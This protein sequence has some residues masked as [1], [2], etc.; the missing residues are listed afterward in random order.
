LVTITGTNLGSPTAFTIGG[1]AAIVISNTGT[2]MVGM[3]MPGAVTGT[4]SLTTAGGSVTSAGTF[5]VSATPAPNAQQGAKLVGTG[6]TGT[7]QQGYA[8]SVSADGNTA[9][10]GG[11]EDDSSQGAAWIYTRSAGVWS[12]QGAKLVGTGNTG[13]ARQGW[14]VSL[15]A[16]GNTAIVGGWFD[17]SQE[18]AAWIYTRSGTTW[19][20]QGAK[21]VGTGNTGAARQGWSV[22]LSADGNTA[23]LGGMNDNSQQG[24]AWIFTRN[25]TTWNQQGAKLVGTGNTGAAFQGRAV[26]LSADGN[27]AIVGG[28]ADN[29]NQ[30]ATWIFTR[31][32]T[33]WSQQGAKLV[34]T[35]NIGEAQQ[36]YS[37]SLSANG[38]TAILGGFADNSY[39]GATWIFTRSGTTW[40]QQGN[41]LVGTGGSNDARQGR[42]VSL[43]ADGNT[44]IVGGLND[45][46]NQGAAWIFTRS[47]TTW[48]QQGTKRIG[49]G[50]IGE[51]QQGQA[52]SLSAD[53][54]TAIVGGIV[55]DSGQGAAWVYHYIPP[56][57]I[58]SFTPASGPV[59][60]LVTITGTNLGSPTAFTIGGIAAI[61]ISNDG[62]SLVGMVMPGA[63]TGTLSVTTVGGSVTAG[64]TFTISTLSG[65]YAQ[66]GNKLLGTGNTGN[67]NQGQVVSVSADGNTAIVGGPADDSNQGAV[68]IYTRSGNIWSQQGT[69]LVGTGNTG[70][71][72]QGIAVSISADG[73]TTI[74]GGFF[75]N[76]GQGAA[77][78]F[79]RSGTTWSQQGNKLVGTGNIGAAQ[80]GIAVSISADGNTAVVGGRNDNTNQGAAWVY[81]RNGA[82][83][84]QQGNKLVGTGGIPGLMQQGTSVSVSADGNTAIVGAPRDNSDQGAAWIYTRSGTTWSQQGTK[85]VGTGNTGTAY[86]GYAVSL[87]AD[88][89]TAMMG[90]FTDNANRGAAWV[91]SRS[92][93]TWSQQG[94]K[95]VGTGSIGNTNQGVAVSLSADGNTA[96]VGGNADNSFMGAIWIYTRSGTNWSQLGNKLVGSGN[97]GNASFGNSVS[98]SADGT[99]TMVGGAGDNSYLGAAWVYN[100]LPP[101][102]ITSFSPSSG[103]IGTLVTITGTDLG[104][105][106]AFIIG[107]TAA[108]VISNTGTSLVGMVMPGAVT[109][110]ISLTNGGGSVT[111]AG[112]FTLNTAPAPNAQQG[113][114]LVGTGN[115][116]DASQYVVSISADGNTA[117]VGGQS[118]NTN[119]GAAWIYTRTGTTWSQQGTKLVG[120]GNT[121]AARQGVSVS[122][123][124]DGNTAIVGG[125]NDNSDQGAAWI[126]TRSG[127][128]WSQQGTKLVGTGNTGAAWQ[129]WAVSLSADG[130]TA[131]VGGRNDNSNQGAAWVFTRSGATWTQQGAKLVGTGNTG[132][133]NQGNA[134]SLSADG[135]TA[136]LGGLFDNSSQGAAWIFVRSGVTWSQQGAK[137]VGTGNTGA[138]NQGGSV[139]LSADGNTAIL[140]GSSDNGTQGATWIFVRSGTTW[141]QQGA[142]LVGTGNIGN[143][144]QGGAVSLSTDGNTA[145]VG[146]TNDNG[147]Q[148]AAWIFTR[149]GTTWSQQGTKLVGTGNTEAAQQGISVSLSADGTT[150]LVGG[151]TDN[152]FQ[153]AVW[154]YTYVPPPTITSFT[155]ASGPVGTLVTITGTNLGNPTAFTIGGT[156]AIV[157]SNTGTSLV[158]MVMPGAV[159]GTIS[160]TTGGGSVIS[161][162]TFTLNTA[163]A[164]NVQQGAKLT[165]TGNTGAAQ[166]GFSVSL[167]ADGNTAIVGGDADNSNRGAVW[168][169]TR[170]GNT[171]SQQGTKLVGTGIGINSQH[172]ISVSISADGNTAIV[173]GPGDNSNQGAVWIYTRNG[174]T[175]SQQGNKLVGTGNT[176]AALQGHAVSLSAD[177]NTAIV[178]GYIDNSNQGAAWVFTRVGTIWS[179]QG[180]KLVGT[181]NTGAAEQGYSVSLSADGNTA[182]VGGYSDNSALGAA[183]VYTRSGNTWS[184]QGNKL[185]GTGSIGIPRQGYAVSL[186][187]DGNTAIMSGS[188]DNSFIGA[189][190][191]FTRSGTTWT[192]QGSKIVGTGYTETPRYGFAVSL[193]ADGNTAMVGG[194]TDNFGQGAVWIYTR[195]G[196]TW[197]QQGSKKV[198]TGNTGAAYQG[199][200]VSLSADGTTAMVGGFGDNSSQGAV[201]VYTYVPPPTITSFSPSSGPIGTL[202]TITGTNLGSPTAFTIG[203]TAAIVISN[204]GTSL[205]GMVMPGA[206]TGT[207]SLTTAGGSVTSAGTFTLST[208]S[209]PNAQQ[210]AK[211][212]GTGNTGAAQQGYAVSL[213][214]DGTTAIVGG[215]ADNSSQG[216]VWIYTRTGAIWSQQGAKLVG[217]GNTGAAQQGWAVS[218]SADGNTAIVGGNQDNSSLGAAWIYTRSGTTWSQQGTKL[219]GTGII[220]IA[221]QGSSVSLSADGTTAILGGI[222]DNSFVG[223]AW[224]FTRSGTTWSQQGAKIVGTGNTG[225]ANQGWSVSLSSDGNTAIVGGMNDN[226]Q[227]GAAWI[228]TRSA[229]TWSQQGAK[230][231]GTGII[232][233]AL[234]GQSVSLSADGNTAIVGGGSDNDNQGTAWIFTRSGTT[235]SQQGT[236]LA[237]TGIIGIANQGRAVSL[238]ADGTTAILG[239]IADNSS[240]GAVWIYTH[241]PP[242]TIASFTPTSAASGATVTL[243]GTNFTGATEVSFGGTAATSFNIV[244]STSITAVIAAGTSGNVSVTT[245]GG[246][247]TLAGFTFIPAPTITS[248]T[249]TSAGSTTTVTLTGTDFTGATA[250]SFGGTAA[251]SFN[252]VSATSITAVVAAGTSGNVS[253]T[254]PGGTGVLAG[255]TFIPAPVITSFTPTSAATGATVTLIGTNF[256]GATAVSF[257][258]TAATSFNVV[259]ATSIT[260]VVA[261]GT[262]GNVSVTTPGGTGVLAGFTFIPAPVITSFTPTNAASGATVTLTGTNFTGA[263]A[264]SFGGTAATSFNVVSA[265]SI[266]AVVAAGTSGNVSVTTPGGT[267][268][269][270]GFTFI[271]APVITSFTPTSAATGATV[272]LTGTNFT[273]ATALSFGGT[274][275][276][277]FNVVSATS[278]TAVV[279]AGTSGNISVTTPSGTGVLAGFTFIPAPV[280]NSFTPTSAGSTTT[281]TLTGTNFTGATALSFGGTAATSFNVVS[282]TSIT[283]VVASG[284]SGNVSVTT[285]GGTG[286]LAGF[287]FT[288]APVI[289][290]FTPTSAATGATVTLTGT[291]FT[292]ATALSFGGTA[293]TSFNVVSAT[294]ITAV[295]AAGTSGNVSVTT[296]GGTG[297]L[298]G[299][300]FIPAPVITSFTP[301]SAAT[302]A[303]VTLTGTNF[304][305]ATAVSFGGT[306]AT[307]FNVVSATSITAVVAAGTSGNVSVTNPGGTGVL[308]GFTFIPAPVISSFTPGSAASASTVTLT[309]TNFTGATALNFGGTAATSFNVVSAT[310][311]T[312]VVA[313]GTSGNVS[314][315]TPGG[316]G[317]L[318][319]FTF[320][321]APVI[322]SFTPTSAATGATVTLTGTNFT[323]ATALSFGGTAATS[324]NVVSATSITAV[325]AAGTSGN[326]SVTTPGGTGVRAGFTLLSS[327]ADLSAMTLS[328]GTL[329]PVFASATTNY[330]ATVPFTTSSITLSPTRSE[331]SA[332][333]KVNGV[334]VGSGTA[335]SNIALAVGTNTISTVVT[336]GDGT[337]SKTYL[338]TI[339]REV[340]PLSINA[341]LSAMTLSS[342]T[343]SP[344]FASATTNY[345]ATVPFTSSSITLSPTRSEGSATIKV[346]GVTVSSGTASGSIALNVGTNTISTVVTAGDGTTTKTY[347]LTLTREVQPLSTDAGLSAMTLSS[348]TLAPVFTSATTNYTATVPFTT[349]SITLSPTRSEGSATIKVNGMT[350]SSG[351]ASGSIALAVGTNTISTVVTAGDG[352]TSKTYLLTLTREVQPLSTDAGLSAM[353]LSSGTLSP[354]FASA[355]TNY[356]ATVPFT[357]SSITL[358]PTR[359]EGTATIKVNGV[360]VG[361]GTASSNIALA[362]GTNT[363]STVVT[364]GDGT[365]SKTYL[366]TLT[367]EVQPL[368]ADAGLTAMTLSSGTLAP[369]FTSAT[370][371][372]TATVPFATS[373]ITL[374]P[375]RSEGSATIKVNGI[376]VGSGT[377]SG[378]IALAVGTNTIT[379]VVTAGD[380]TTIKTYLLTI[381]R[382]V[383]PLSTDAGLSAIALSSGT[384]SP[385]FASATTNYSATVPF[386]T[387]SITLSPTRSEGSATIKVNGVT[388]GSGTASSNIALAVGTNTISTVVTAGDGTTTKTYLLTLTREV[389][390]LST[391]AGLS[392]IAL[393]SGTLSP[394]F[395]SA[396]TNYSAT[397]P[398]TTSSITLSPTR[399]EGTATIKVNGITVGSG[400]ASGSIALAVGTNTISTVVTAGDGSTTKTYSII[401]TRTV[402]SNNANLSALTLSNGTLSPVFAPAS[403]N[404]VAFVNTNVNNI[405]LSPGSE[406]AGATIKVNG[407]AVISQSASGNIPL[408]VGSNTIS[409]EVKAEDG[410]SLK[411]Y[412]LKV[413]R[414]R[415]EQ[416][417]TN[418]SGNATASNIAREVVVISPSLPLIITIPTGTSTSTTVAYGDLIAGGSGKIPPTSISTPF[419]KIEIPSSTTVIASG[420]SWTGTFLAPAITNYNLPAKPGIVIKTGLIVEIGSPDFSLSFDKALRIVLYGQAG[421][422]VARVHSN[423]YEEILSTGSDSQAAGD[424]L[425]PDASFKLNSGSD[426]VIWTKGLSRFITFTETEDLDVALVTTDKTELT[427]D[428]IKGTNKDLSSITTAISLPVTGSNGSAITWESS[429]PAVVSPNGQSVARPIFGSGDV[430]VTLKATLTK[431]SITDTKTIT[432]IVLQLPNQAPAMNAIASQTLCF[433]TALQTIALSGIT[434]G[435]ESGQTTQLSVSSSNSG[436][437][438]SLSVVP[439]NNGTAQLRF[440]PGNSSGGTAT[441]T[442]TVK[443]N[444][445]TA[446]GGVD[447]FSRTFTVTVNPLPVINISSDLGTDISKGLTAQLTASGGVSYTWATAQG[448]IGGQNSPIL[449][450][451]PSV[452]TTYTVTV[453]NANG[454]INTHSMTIQVINDYQTLNI[455]NVLSPNGDGKNDFLIIKN[456]DMYPNNTLKVFNK[457]GREIFTKVNYGNNW[458][459]T[460]NGSAL[461]EDTYYYILDFGP[462]LPKLKGYVSI[463]R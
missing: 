29:T 145:I 400:T 254:T 425:A 34:G 366:L 356:T 302:G 415:P 348:G 365:T 174:T 218:L 381:T 309:G 60:T 1:T 449:R 391:D 249:P 434:P 442:V 429:N 421:M 258:G 240:Q 235:W 266:T 216:A 349:S 384:L 7:A 239:G 331:G 412:T 395:A 167:S 300:T 12:Q 14:S 325:V 184:Q 420:T 149:S 77:W 199:F 120:T 28:D 288:P 248:F 54:T 124:A 260:A 278:I 73:N 35:G 241:V 257:G 432:I 80:Q 399:S 231:V 272:T 130:N 43:S 125:Y 52:V 4:I 89:N 369:V 435:P 44:A 394:V 121:G 196:T 45:N 67:S 3:V 137:L 17:N 267:G 417:L 207:I 161:A 333:I 280:I 13:A 97:I 213:S 306:A 115:I 61:V 9:I 263:T 318:V 305:G 376:T 316:T 190:W 70:A 107:G 461:V 106:T 141:S 290:S 153:G 414:V 131:L 404:Y 10:V 162:G 452:N 413:T 374:S 273:G 386:T 335:S 342:G 104:S 71:A 345:S 157:I 361:S 98:L 210:G 320:I 223:A 287:T 238:S 168:I 2:S 128:T 397:V 256:T 370:T 202:V 443:D 88:G 105:P 453:T 86:Q 8:V 362:V 119:Q 85:L 188:D 462:G 62:T 58:T 127:T 11:A 185:V 66:Q 393:S 459:G 211:L 416:I 79:T 310:S 450:V 275:A 46:T 78:V 100:Y 6:N 217:T 265:S 253:V 244:S 285:P 84:S 74:V 176:G 220:G 276:T 314:V 304:T 299:F 284:T 56:P 233:I 457:A 173:G 380:G 215:F 405:T 148:G 143:A 21:L 112:T 90:G 243:T 95:L 438:S 135:N 282:A 426:L 187:A 293:A 22:S 303:T 129:G 192:Q 113:V 373:S 195:S 183:W 343:L 23:I 247:G 454:C 219:V 440:T 346:N 142:K 228:Y 289:T 25:G 311:I 388:V 431:G 31:T 193:S 51:A 390:P 204:T 122:I 329:S 222:G 50:S 194:R 144:Q 418:D 338:L 463:V 37:V 24:A 32:G 269:L 446:N 337:T 261:A 179:Q 458:D 19:S 367:R 110:I 27:T 166:Q 332:T 147:S 437:F 401:I 47:G 189:A 359:S 368:S 358:S 101:P 296:P 91:F 430:T 377:A 117:I 214:S 109:G 68:W 139:S 136:I 294:S 94:N 177:G 283:A 354:V 441:I 279:P 246:T 30:G 221:R 41:K 360:T 150:A 328:S 134:I 72:R 158:G 163:P 40:S 268:V 26:S 334:T 281:V 53:G 423:K 259:S 407:I 411:T 339:T 270:A 433:T 286:V 371:N 203:G 159:T 357:S 350:V 340:Q 327:N 236:K 155:P 387:S 424:A 250:V 402:G 111:S 419:A 251:T 16:D 277:S 392:A 201:W 262:S 82:T 237:G 99:T 445:G 234:Q 175:W 36:G 372:Y 271:P 169:Y 186:S 312:A 39:Q 252:V 132:A 138:A 181:G 208:A 140:G 57:T 389:Q 123:N 455:N 55:D 242:P 315:T 364:A 295:V 154:V 245:P 406:H 230:L 255:F 448:I 156:A 200:S 38:N 165:G 108:I 308:A 378:S 103:P 385:V 198:G 64:G 178:G 375:T 422:R 336:A 114:K 15:S 313:A 118:D 456:L 347:L 93:T 323:G 18:G 63:S 69:K 322:T 212:V 206:V 92:G 382:E 363:I 297:V 403:L 341:G 383:Q 330:S 160:L 170:S 49:T 133:A 396:T 274:A 102:T 352:T 182:I 264:L 164:P 344:V 379:T 197:S 126:Y 224:I 65:T 444:G 298:A 225:A 321:P 291:N 301:T 171:W 428:L 408:A 152:V 180:A 75:D 205:V 76:S 151:N 146:G 351:T 226:S 292:G 447:S 460:F 398:F 42:A 410:I 324:F 48:S 319:G 191:V 87:S 427:D 355:T 436:L 20:Q 5:T 209:A 232:G 227:K 83:W 439:G 307:S 172:G 81:T 59:G 116:G 353:T 33:T 326:V 451:R 409:L 96:I 317:T 229:S